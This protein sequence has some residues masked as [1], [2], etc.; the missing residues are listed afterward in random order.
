MSRKRT[1]EAKE[2]RLTEVSECRWRLDPTGDM[3]V[4][5]EIYGDESIVRTLVEEIR[6]GKEW[7]SLRQV[8]NVACLPGILKASLAMA[9]VHPGYGFPIGGVGAFDPKEGVVMVAGV[10]FDCNCGVRTMRTPVKREEIE[11]RRGELADALF[12]KVPA[13]VGSVGDFRLSR[14]EIDEVLTRGAEFALSRGYGIPDDLAWIEEGGCMAGADPGAVSDTAKKRQHRQVGTLGSGNHYVEIQYVDE[15]H[16]EAAAKAY[17]LEKNGVVISIHTGS[18]ALGHQIGT[19]YLKVLKRASEKYE[20][21]IREREL[22]GAPIESPE[23]KRYLSAV[24]AGMN[25]AFANRQ[26]LGHLARQAVKEVL[27]VT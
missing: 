27:P 1:L 4:P 6:E 13:G 18:R 14:S 12:R 23:G 10:G 5:G 11:T 7:S 22:V 9:D 15:I 8:K 20:I 25:C 21:P 16:D 3:R 19:D 24:N 17:G 2:Y 26:A